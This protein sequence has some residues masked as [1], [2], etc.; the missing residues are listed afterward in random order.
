MKKI[1]N[2]KILFGLILLLIA[3]LILFF[4]FNEAND[5]EEGHI[6]ILSYDLK[7]TD[8]TFVFFK[9]SFSIDG[10]NDSTEENGGGLKIIVGGKTKSIT[11]RNLTEEKVTWNTDGGFCNNNNDCESF[12]VLYGFVEKDV[13][14][15]SVVMNGK[16]Y[17][18][19]ILTTSADKNVWFI[20]VNQIND[21]TSIKG[22]DSANKEI[23]SF[24]QN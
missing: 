21:I 8:V 14:K 15:I 13:T 10:F 9:N 12:D 16:S 6:D 2:F 22:Y 4:Y 20:V 18:P 24:T 11:S 17:S 7:D 5:N 19:D 1:I 3:G 23:Y